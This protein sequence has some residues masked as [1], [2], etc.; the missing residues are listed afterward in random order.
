[1]RISLELRVQKSFFAKAILIGGQFFTGG[2][3]TDIEEFGVNHIPYCNEHNAFDSE[4]L[5]SSSSSNV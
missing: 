1:M 2:L 3:G 4:T 5:H